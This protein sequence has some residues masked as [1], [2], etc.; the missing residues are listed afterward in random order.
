MAAS[1]LNISVNCATPR[2]EGNSSVRAVQNISVLTPSVKLPPLPL[3]RA[4]QKKCT[5]LQTQRNLYG[6][7]HRN[8]KMV[9]VMATGESADSGIDV[10]DILKRVQE[11][12]SFLNEL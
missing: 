3:N 12:V 8:I 11:V 5:Q 7:D 4:S 6:G 10:D 2:L 1:L 9:V